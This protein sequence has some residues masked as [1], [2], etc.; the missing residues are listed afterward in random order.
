MKNLLPL[1]FCF[2]TF[3]G[4]CQNV[5]KGTVSDIYGEPI[6]GVRIAVMN[7]TY[8]VPSNSIGKYYLELDKS[9]DTVIIRYSMLGFAPKVDTI[10]MNKPLVLHNIELEEKSTDLGTVEIFADNRDFGKEV[11]QKVMANK[12]KMKK[13][14]ESYQCETYIKTSLEKEKKVKLKDLLN[15][16]PNNP[17]EPEEVPLLKERMNFIESNSVTRF[18]QPNAY[19]ETIIAHQD[20]AEKTAR[21]GGVSATFSN[22]NSPVPKQYIPHNPYIFYEKVEDGDFNLYQNLIDLPKVCNNPIVSPL[23]INNFINYK[24]T[25]NNV[26]FEGDQKIYD[27]RIEPRFNEIPLFIGNLY[28]MDSLWIIKSIDLAVNPNGMEFFKFFRINEDYTEIEGKWVAERREF[29]YTIND[30]SHLVLGNTRVQH[31][32]YQFDV[33]F[34]RKSFNNI[35]MEYTDEAFNRDSTYWDEIRPYKLKEQELQFI[36]EQDSIE[37]VLTSD[38]YIDSVNEEF[39]KVTFWDVTLNGVGFRD[40]VK[41]HEIFINPLISQIQPLAVGGYRHRIGGHYSKEF[42]NAQAYKLDGELDYG[43]RNKDVKGHLGVEYTYLPKH[44]GSIRVR[45][46][47]KYDFVTMDQSIANFFSLRNRVR[48]TFINIS[49]R[50][51]IVN[52][53]YGRLTFDYSKRVDITGLDNPPWIDT[54]E[55][56]GF[57]QPAQPFETYTVSIFELQLVYRFKQQYILKGNKK[58]IIGTEFPELRFTYK[59]GVPDLFNS[60]VNFD[61]VEIGLSD[62][63]DFGTFGDLKWDIEA[64]TFF[65]KTA[66]EVQFIERRFFRGSDLLIFTNPLNTLQLLDSTFNTTRPYL[67]FFAIHHFNGAILGKVPLINKTK[68]QMVAGLGGLFIEEANYR[69]VEFYAGLE[70][71]IK[72]RKQLF[73]LSVFYVVRENNATTINLNFKVGLD[74]FN[75]FTNSWSY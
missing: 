38:T 37:Q 13:Q 14:F 67:Q 9:I 69:H 16:D 59:K 44:F 73:K 26:F 21:S 7:S 3:S 30:G 66:S 6:P 47:D 19:K 1:L 33:E 63:V 62:K 32:N 36:H 42:E 25:L 46:G 70:R 31:G 27:I 40:R 58:L 49:K 57:W 2:F 50:Y 17:S 53:L 61:F 55:Q 10:L 75:T 12:S 23:A 52:G 29:T 43:F 65:G 71:A 5:L 45:G 20:Y 18:K 24:F 35:V 41:K 28:V 68:I 11:I 64:G 48:K 4:I 22:Q 54:L 60:D 74:F 56:S 15:I 72:I 39:N 51:E 8:G 34:D